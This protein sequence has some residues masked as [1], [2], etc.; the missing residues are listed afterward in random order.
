M[1][2]GGTNIVVQDVCPGDAF[3]HVAVAFDPV[4]AQLMLNA[5]DPGGARPVRC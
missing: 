4:V 3:E 5:L 2:D 1:R